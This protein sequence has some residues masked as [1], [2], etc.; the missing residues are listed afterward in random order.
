MKA[1]S[2][3]VRNL[4]ATH[5]DDYPE[6]EFDVVATCDDGTT[7]HSDDTYSTHKEAQTACDGFNVQQGALD[8]AQWE[9]FA[10]P[11]KV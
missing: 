4:T 10:T 2:F 9:V 1:I 6:Q 8:V 3:T 5:P 7:R 11:S